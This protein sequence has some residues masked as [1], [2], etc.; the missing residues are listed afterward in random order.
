MKLVYDINQK[1][2]LK[3]N[4]VYAFQ[5]LLAI[6]AATLLVPVLADSTGLYLNQPAALFGAGMGTLFYI[7]IATRKKS[8]VFLGSSFAFISPLA[9]ACAYGFLG[10]F[11]GSLFAG[12]VYVLIALIVK[13]T[14]TAWVTK[15]LP[16]VVIGPTVALIGLSLCGS[17]VNNLNN[18]AA[19][20]YNLVAILVGLIAFFITVF[21][22]V[23]GTQSMKM[24]PFIIGILGAYVIALILTFIG[25]ASGCE[26]LQLVKLSAF[27]NVQLFKVP[28]FTFL[29]MFGAYKD[30]T[31]TIGSASDVLSLFVLFAPVAFVTL[32][33]HIADHENLSSIIGHDL[34]TDP[35]LDRTLLGDGA[36]S[37]VGAL[38]GGCPNTT[39]GES[40][41]CIA[42]TGNA[43]VSTIAIAAVYC[44]LLSFF[45]PFV[46]FVNSIPTCIVGGVCI[47]LYGFIAVSGLK[48]IQPVDLNDHRNLFVVAAILVCGI[49]GLT[50]NFGSVQIS[51][52]ATGLIVG[53]LV[54]VIFNRRNADKK[55]E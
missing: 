54:N 8:P 16:P 39:Y 31:N 35:G 27:D 11:V 36:G 53:I 52:I 38:F 41:G 32:A 29:G 5:Q 44:V 47:A 45:D 9:G 48:M 3:K 46:C 12:L 49:G 34:I 18:T 17:A 7:F 30:A 42:I 13:K 4:L 23:K 25:R 2:P 43:S 1:P 15:L 37:I 10:I 19:G 33:E 22:S 6:M 55:A 28:R 50:L 20:S 26:A 40:V 21:A 24:V 14:G 51:A